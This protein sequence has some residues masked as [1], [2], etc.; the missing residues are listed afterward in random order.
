M[1][2]YQLTGDWKKLSK[3]MVAS[4][5]GMTTRLSLAVRKCALFVEREIVKGIQ[6]Q[7]PAGGSSF[8][9]LHPFTVAQKKR[10]KALIH[11]GDLVNSI[12]TK[13]VGLLAAFAGLHKMARDREGNLLINIA[14]IM[15][16]G[17]V[18]DITPKMRRWLGAQG[19][20]NFGSA[21][22]SKKGVITIPKRPFIDPV[23]KSRAVS[24]KCGDIMEKSVREFLK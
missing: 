17:A 7:R 3:K 14:E 5:R 8:A 16:G 24:E 21:P 15:E 18:I 1:P 2:K 13:Q 23:V 11:H 20:Y 12:T 9:A 19:F 6:R 4:T 22:T 10:S